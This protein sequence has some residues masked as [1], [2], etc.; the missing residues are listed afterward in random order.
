MDEETVVNVS[1]LESVFV[2]SGATPHT[3]PPG[4]NPTR[5][6]GIKWIEAIVYSQVYNK[7]SL[8]IGRKDRFC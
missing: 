7:D 4:R 5:T 1:L 3:P 6:P 2:G 8:Q